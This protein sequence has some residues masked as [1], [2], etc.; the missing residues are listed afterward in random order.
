MTSLLFSG[1]FAHGAPATKTMIE[2]ADGA[3][4]CYGEVIA[5][6]SQ[7]AN[8]LVAKGVKPGDRVAVQ[9]EKSTE[10]VILYLACLRAGAVFL[11]LNT[12][13]TA[14]ELAY[15]IGDAEPAMIVCSSRAHASLEQL[16]VR[17]GASLETLDPAG[18]GSLSAYARRQADEF[19]N[20]AR[21]ADDLAAILYTSGTTGKPK[22]AMLSHGALLSNATALRELWRVTPSDRLLHALPLFHTHGLFV[23]IN[24]T[25]SAGASLILLPG[26][27]ANE[28]VRFLPRATMFMGV[29]TFYVR[30]LQHAALTSELVGNARLF[31]CGSAPLDADTHLQWRQ[32]TGHAI[33]ERYGMTETN[34]ITSNPY[35]GDRIAG[36]VGLPLSGVSLR[37]V[38]EVTGTECPAGAVG[39]IEIKSPGLFSGY[40]R[41]PD[42]TASEFK[43]DGFF[44]TG[45]LGQLDE[46][47]Y[48]R[49]VGRGKDLIITGGLNVYPKEIED[50]I[51]TLPGVLESAVVGVPHPD[52]GEGVVAA[53]VA[54]NGA[55]LDS[56]MILGALKGRL[57]KFK[58]PKH[59][60]VLDVLPRNTMGKVKKNELRDLLRDVCAAPVA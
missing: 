47:G 44:V 16:A 52:F 58:I 49:I 20:V 10:A 59:V 46:R 13:Y 33:L 4:L 7:F 31:V 14:E 12:A 28:V 35:E 40:W 11:P 3:S 19:T 24:V 30:L 56:E 26:F 2:T 36:S 25:L 5:G 6:S 50:V 21:S 22:G 17:H 18:E 60:A 37:I 1:L 48:V 55:R 43:P 54:K 45:D 53:V 39:M 29:P 34:M 38:D 23:A 51:N 8:A 42:K 9:V 41:N 15:L 57:A 27:D 32:R